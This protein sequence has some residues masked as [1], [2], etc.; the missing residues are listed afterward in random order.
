[1]RD[2][3]GTE[4]RKLEYFN[5]H[6]FQNSLVRS[7]RMH[8]YIGFWNVLRYSILKFRDY[9]LSQIA[10]FAPYAG[11]RIWCHRIRGVKIGKDSVIG[12]HCILDEI[13][14]SFITIEDEVSLAGDV[15]ILTHSN[16]YEYYKNDIES[17]VAPVVIKKNAWITINVTILPGVTIGE[18]SVIAAGSVVTRDIPAHVL[19]GGVPA[20]VIKEFYPKK[21][22]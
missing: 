6:N 16:P 15:F 21:E 3:I 9:V 22:T 7:A 12:F 11:I 20:K 8:G 2:L 13:F 17:F 1:M 19:A 4:R 14:P 10:Y 5:P 18:G